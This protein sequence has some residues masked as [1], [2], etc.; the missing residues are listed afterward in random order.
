MI[1]NHRTHTATTS[2]YQTRLEGV[3]NYFAHFTISCHHLMTY[4][5]NNNNHHFQTGDELSKRSKFV[6][7]TWIGPNVSVMKKA[8]M[9][10]DKAFVK[11]VI[12]VGNGSITN[13]D[14]D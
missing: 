3:H 14:D 9:G 1:T 11:E 8:K 2:A 5:Q 13:T 4:H 7:V 12:Q 10:T 6:F